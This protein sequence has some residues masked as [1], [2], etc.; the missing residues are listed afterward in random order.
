V[1]DERNPFLRR[2]ERTKNLSNSHRRAPKQEASLTKRVKG[3]QTPASGSREVK[4]DVRK[5]RVLRLEAKTTKNKSFSV[6]LAMVRAIEEAA[7]SGAELPV[8]VVEFTDGFGRQLAEVAVVP[9]YVLDDICEKS[10][11]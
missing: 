1:S 9:T 4:G 5:K 8:I 2:A 7:A 10:D 11:D 3:M 6:T